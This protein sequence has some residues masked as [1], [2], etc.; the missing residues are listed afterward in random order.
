M[1]VVE[2]VGGINLLVVVVVERDKGEVREGNRKI[3]M[4]VEDFK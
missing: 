2:V 3:E 4:G 1:V